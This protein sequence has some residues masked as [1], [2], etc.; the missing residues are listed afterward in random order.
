MGKEVKEKVTLQVQDTRMVTAEGEEIF[1]E[2]LLV[3][4]KVLSEV[5]FQYGL[6][7]GVKELLELVGMDVEVLPDAEPLESVATVIKEEE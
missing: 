6:G 4:G 5:A 2:V 1:G 3:N 7:N